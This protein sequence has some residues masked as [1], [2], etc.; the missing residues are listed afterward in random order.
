VHRFL[1]RLIFNP[2]LNATGV[3]WLATLGAF[4]ASAAFH[5]V[6]VNHAMRFSPPELRE[7]VRQRL[8]Y[9]VL[10]FV[11]QA[12]LCYGERLIDRFIPPLGRL[13]RAL[14]YPMQVLVTALVISPFGPLFTAPLEAAGLVVSI[15][16]LF[17]SVV[18]A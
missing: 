16:R 10:F 11:T 2:T 15:S 9:Q 14:P 6:L 17:P 13:A 3:R 7:G 1:K 8:Y 18:V 12:M 4:I 5:E